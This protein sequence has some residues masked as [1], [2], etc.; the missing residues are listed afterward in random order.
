ML[1]TAVKDRLIRENPCQI[2]G[3]GLEDTEERPVLSVSEVFE[4][5][6][7]IKPRYRSLVLLATFGSMR[8]G[9]LAGLRRRHL[10]LD[11]RTVRVRETV[12]HVLSLVEPCFWILRPRCSISCSQTLRV[13]ASRPPSAGVGGCG[14]S[15]GTQRSRWPTPTGSATGADPATRPASATRTTR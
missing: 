6:D 9:E 12:W 14:R 15:P 5:A 2:D 13:S 4:L 7:A 11:A 8:W 1:N 10:D 3:A